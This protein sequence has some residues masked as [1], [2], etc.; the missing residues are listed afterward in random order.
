MYDYLIVGAGLTGA[1]FANEARKHGK[2]VLVI[3]KRPHIAGNIYTEN[4]NGIHVHKYGPHIFHTNNK[5]VWDYMNQFTDFNRFTNTPIANYLGEIYSLPFNMFTFN[6][7]WGV[8]TPEQAREKIE[9]QKQEAG[10]TTPKNLEE[11]AISL[12][13]RDIYELL[14]KGYTEKQWG[15]PCN[16]LPA[17]IINRLPVRFTYDNNYFNAL[18]QGIPVDGYTEIIARMLEGIEVRLDCD[19]FADRAQLSSLAQ[20]VVFTGQI[21][22]YFDYELGTLEYRTLRFETETLTE[23]NNFQGNAIVNYTDSKTPYT[24]CIEHKHFYP[25]LETASTVITREYPS[26]WKA[27]DEPYYPVNNSRNN[28]L[29]ES[30]KELAHRKCPNVIFAGRLG[31]YKYYDMDIAALKALELVSEVFG[32]V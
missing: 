8:I 15:R 26:E 31:G 2:S 9:S 28:S 19:F 18:Y 13:G 11:Q 21:D 22:A 7:I 24:R 10:I 1:I 5:T 16:E 25:G 4:V 12:V 17:F 3:D 23:T 27:G 29:Y 6:K 20:N 32:R 14:I 30:Y